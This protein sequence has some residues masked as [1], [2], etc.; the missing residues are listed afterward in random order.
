[1][2]SC[3]QRLIPVIPRLR[4]GVGVGVVP[5]DAFGAVDRSTASATTRL[6][7]PPCWTT[8]LTVR[9]PIPT[10]R[11]LYLI[12]LFRLTA[13]SSRGITLQISVD[14]R[15]KRVLR[16]RTRTYPFD[17]HRGVERSFKDLR[18]LGPSRCKY[19]SGSARTSPTW[20][21]DGPLRYPVVTAHIP[22]VQGAEALR[23]PTAACRNCRRRDQMYR[24]LFGIKIG[25]S[26]EP[27]QRLRRRARRPT[28]TASPS[29][30]G[31][32]LGI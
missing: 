27:W 8:C 11:E 18:R 17:H 23:R 7:S 15:G 30:T 12:R 10:A 22:V 32:V 4:S 1:M 28:A 24:G 14:G 31:A 21:A 6:L 9:L 13:A 3:L 25:L 19:S 5:L 20:S 16:G 26:R 29:T 2:A